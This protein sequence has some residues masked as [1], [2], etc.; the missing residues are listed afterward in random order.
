MTEKPPGPR[1]ASYQPVD[2]PPAGTNG[3]FW[4]SLSMFH[5]PIKNFIRSISGPGLGACISDA[6]VFF[7]EV[8][9]APAAIA[10]AAT[11][12]TSFIIGF[13][14]LIDFPLPLYS[15]AQRHMQL[16]RCPLT[17]AFQTVSTGAAISI[18]FSIF[19][20]FG[21]GLASLLLYPFE[22]FSQRPADDRLGKVLLA[23]PQPLPSGFRSFWLRAG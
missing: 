21:A 20:A 13:I 16:H 8:C 15:P 19:A 18:C 9:C 1:R 4:Y 11:I 22:T 10:N 14:R 23:F 17:N 3:V 6:A 5:R 2:F 7:S 12:T